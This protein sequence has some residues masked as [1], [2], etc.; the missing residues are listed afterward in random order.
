MDDIDISE[1]EF[2]KIFKKLNLDKKSLL[3]V[4]IPK[5]KE[6]D[7]YDLDNY[8]DDETALKI[9]E[10]IMSFL[11]RYEGDWIMTLKEYS[12]NDEDAHDHYND[13][14]KMLMDSHRKLYIYKCSIEDSNISTGI[15][16]VTTINF[17][18]L[19]V[20]EFEDKY[21]IKVYN[22]DKGEKD[23]QEKDKTKYRLSKQS[24]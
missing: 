12:F 11:F 5:Y 23:A 19:L 15:S 13:M 2:E 7:R 21:H 14:I 16:F 10:N 24:I 22:A 17:D 6:Y 18:K 3:Y 8:S 1:Q 4:D 20:K 9:E